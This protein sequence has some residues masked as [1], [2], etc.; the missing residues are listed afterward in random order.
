MLSLDRC[1]SVVPCGVEIRTVD[2]AVTDLRA[3]LTGVDTE[4]YLAVQSG[5]AGSLVS[6]TVVVSLV[7]E[8]AVADSGRSYKKHRPRNDGQ[9]DPPPMVTIEPAGL[10]CLRWVPPDTIVLRD[11]HSTHF[12]G[13][14]GTHPSGV[15]PPGGSGLLW[16]RPICNLRL[17]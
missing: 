17:A 1:S 8:R 11:G 16:G 3:A 7:S 2:L 14:H 5:T 9:H 6:T 13:T 10:T 4:G 12:S 15:P